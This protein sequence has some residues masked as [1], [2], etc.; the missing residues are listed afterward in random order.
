MAPKYDRF[1]DPSPVSSQSLS[2][3]ARSVRTASQ[4]C[5]RGAERRELLHAGRFRVS[6]GTS[7]DGLAHREA[8]TGHPGKSGHHG[9]RGRPRGRGPSSPPRR[10]SRPRS[11]GSRAAE[12]IRAMR[13]INVT[14]S[15]LVHD[16]AF[17]TGAAGLAV[18][19]G[20]LRRLGRLIWP[21]PEH[22]R[23]PRLVGRDGVTMALNVPRKGV[24]AEARARE[25]RG[26][27]RVGP[28]P[29]RV[30]GLELRADRRLARGDG[31]PDQRRRGNVSAAVAVAVS[32]S[33]SRDRTAG[34]GQTSQ[35]SVSCPEA[36]ASTGTRW[37]PHRSRSRRWLSG[38]PLASALDR[39]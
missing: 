28:P 25:R 21:P 18:V 10:S 32:I 11:G 13:Q 12:G 7:I 26:R 9:V 17:G 33:R 2:P 4:D 24:P 1:G 8:T 15:T 27:Q 19:V 31:G 34:A 29:R 14:L 37:A 22:G 23:G 3:R 35:E 38:K 5:A 20:A 16:G 39:F 6:D 36:E 30:D